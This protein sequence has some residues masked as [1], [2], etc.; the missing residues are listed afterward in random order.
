[1]VRN[2]TE[3]RPN[4]RAGIAPASTKKTTV[5]ASRWLAS[6]ETAQRPPRAAERATLGAGGA[7]SGV[8]CVVGLG[9]LSFPG[10]AFV[11]VGVQGVGLPR[12]SGPGVAFARVVTPNVAGPG[13]AVP[14]S[15]TPGST[16]PG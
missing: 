5:W 16:A 2:A 9:D 13:G 10:V 3:T 1:M 12:G 4:S 14:G 7:A 8:S 11:R 15:S 6:A